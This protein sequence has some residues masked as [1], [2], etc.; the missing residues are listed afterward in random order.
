M[1]FLPV[2]VSFPSGV[3]A[4]VDL[5]GREL[6]G[7][8]LSSASPSPGATVSIEVDAD[9]TGTPDWRP[10]SWAP[11][12]S[13]YVDLSIVVNNKYVQVPEAVRRLPDSVRFTVGSL[14]ST[15]TLTLVLKPK[16]TVSISG[17]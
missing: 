2:S 8:I 6:V 5:D 7:L 4:A 3:S 16:C 13:S 15:G 1:D 14:S 17:C 9:P 12:N 11:T 10:V